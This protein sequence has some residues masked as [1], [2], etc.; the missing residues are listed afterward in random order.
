M[1]NK[2]IRR[3]KKRML[4]GF[5]RFDN[6]NMYVRL[7]GEISFIFFYP[8]LYGAGQSFNA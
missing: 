4:L 6:Q 7:E 1:E 2:N 3:R 5:N 8:D